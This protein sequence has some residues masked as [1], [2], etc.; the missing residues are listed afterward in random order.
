MLKI[1]SYL[2][3]FFTIQIISNGQTQFSDISTKVGAFSRIGFGA[4][5]IG[6]ANTLASVKEGN[7]ISYYNPANIIYQ[8]DNLLQTGY[9]FLSLDRNL[10]FLSFTKR[11]EFGKKEDENGNTKPKSTAGISV[12]LIN[13]GVSNI[14]GRDGQGKPIGNFSTS[15][16]QFYFAVANKF[17]EKLSIGISFKFYYYK[18]FE[19]FS[20]NGFGLDLGA[21]YIINQ[22]MSVSFVLID[23]NSKYTWDSG[24]L[25]GTNGTISVDKFPILKK[26]GVSYKLDKNLIT[27]IEIEN[28]NAKTNFLRI[29]AEYN[30]L[31]NIYF[32]AG[33][34]KINLNNF[35]IPIRPSAGF[36]YFYEVNKYIIGVE[37]AF[38]YEPYSSFDQHLIGINFRF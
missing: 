6:M 38:S 23:L 9:T 33:I 26:L 5:G 34:D 36:S 28:S 25:Y 13:S 11:F 24:K 14:D 37:Y 3:L 30:P 8:E 29:G 2:I 18:L 32:R 1:I 19:N 10:N 16:N 15:E 21:L 27:A 12:G 7:V 22:S 35:E 17:S 4:R 20:S 31:E